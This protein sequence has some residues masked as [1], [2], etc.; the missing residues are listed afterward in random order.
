MEGHKP[1]LFVCVQRAFAPTRLSD[2]LLA[3]AY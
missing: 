2:D 1:K 3:Q